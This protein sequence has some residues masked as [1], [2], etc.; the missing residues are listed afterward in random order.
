MQYLYCVFCKQQ[1]IL[2]RG[3][4]NC[5]ENA[6]TYAKK[7]SL[8]MLKGNKKAEKNLRFLFSAIRRQ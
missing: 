6:H 5:T 1:A 4:E 3:N 2:M 8:N 7:P